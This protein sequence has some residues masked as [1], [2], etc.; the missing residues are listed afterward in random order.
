MRKVNIEEPGTAPAA[1]PLEQTSALAGAETGLQ[2]SA[3]EL[4]AT[5]AVN[6]PDDSDGAP[7]LAEVEQPPVIHLDQRDA[8]ALPD[9]SDVD[10][11]KIATMTLTK[12][13]WVLPAAAEKQAQG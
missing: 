13:G 9:A 8:N 6:L 4:E 1:E 2:V 11:T 5:P 7:L 10:P 12:Q 3:D